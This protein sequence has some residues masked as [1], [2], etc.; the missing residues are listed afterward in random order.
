MIY[1]LVDSREEETYLDDEQQLVEPINLLQE[2][3]DQ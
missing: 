2:Y 3:S 1:Y